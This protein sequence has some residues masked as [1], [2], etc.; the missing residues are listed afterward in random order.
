MTLYKE[1]VTFD[2]YLEKEIVLRIIIYQH[3]KIGRKD[4][5]GCD[6]S[7]IYIYD[8]EGRHYRRTEDPEF[9]FNYCK[10]LIDN[11]KLNIKLISDGPDENIIY[12]EGGGDND[13]NGIPEY[14]EYYHLAYSII[15]KE[16]L[17]NELKILEEEIEDMKIYYPIN[18]NE[19]N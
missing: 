3:N 19:L 12:F 7:D 10:N 15:K 17:L 13:Y 18:T 1:V 5:D 9:S 11:N 14:K 6:S 2:D 8:S 16:K 4:N